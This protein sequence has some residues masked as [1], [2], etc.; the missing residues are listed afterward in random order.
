[1]ARKD[2]PV[3]ELNEKVVSIN[4]VSKVVKGGRRFSLS[5]LVVVGDG[6]GKVGVGMGKS[7][8]VPNAISKGIEDAKKNMF[9]VPLIGGTLPHE[10]TGQFGAGRVMLK[11]A[12]PGTGVVAGGPV[13]AVLE[14]AGVTDVLSKSL[15]SSNAINIVR[16]TVAGL[17]ELVSAQEMAKRR[18]KTVAE[19]FGQEA[20]VTPAPLA[21]Q[22]AN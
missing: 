3:S 22:E 4:R 18:G 14:A 1:M 7:S 20:Q 21:E 13:R 10:I 8:E 11:P 9:S 15:G 6:E 2:T 17:Q 12:A 16:A 19:I 5:A